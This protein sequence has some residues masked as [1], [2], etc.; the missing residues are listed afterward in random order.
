MAELM[1]ELMTIVYVSGEVYT[2]LIKKLNKRAT[3][4]FLQY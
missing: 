3:D 4:A 2:S 1:T